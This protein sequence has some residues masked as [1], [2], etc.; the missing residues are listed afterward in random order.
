MDRVILVSL[1]LVGA[2]LGLGCRTEC[3]NHPP[4]HMNFTAFHERSSRAVQR[5]LLDHPTDDVRGWWYVMFISKDCYVETIQICQSSSR[6]AVSEARKHLLSLRTRKYTG[7]GATFAVAPDDT[8]PPNAVS[9]E[10]Y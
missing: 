4:Q 9:Y 1:G 8:C 7:E 5:E 3:E 6:A 10:E 2:V